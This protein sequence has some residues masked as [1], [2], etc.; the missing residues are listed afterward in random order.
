MY[1]YLVITLLVIVVIIYL[2][3]YL[4]R[5]R[6]PH[7]FWDLQP[8]S[9]NFRRAGILSKT[10]LAAIQLPDF[11][12]VTFKIDDPKINLGIVEF[13]DQHFLKGYHYTL[14]YLSWSLA[15][16]PYSNIALLTRDQKK[17]VGTIST[18]EVSLVI[19]GTQI[20]M[21]YVDYLAVHKSYR[22]K[23]LATAL[24]S[25]VVESYPLET[26]LFKIEETPLPFD[27]VCKFRYYVYNLKSLATSAPQ[28]NNKPTDWLP[29]D[30]SNI[31]L[32]Y[33]YYQ[34]ECRKFRYY[35]TYTMESFRN[36]FLPVDKILYSYVK[37]HDNR[38]TGF[39]SYFCIDM[40]DGFLTFNKQTTRI[41][42]SLVF[43]SDNITD[44]VKSLLEMTKSLGLDYFVVTNL[45][46]NRVFIDRMSFIPAKRCYLQMY[47]YGTRGPLD[48]SE[49]LINI[50]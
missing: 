38:V 4:K 36:W 9:R 3:Q 50:P 24:I 47:N 43:L 11:I 45:G 5:E 46:K 32:A 25:K 27:A 33:Q 35:Q 29:L 12:T 23:R 16:T 6:T 14:P 34:T 28:P 40:K 39:A 31:E 30:I 8:V 26:F 48:P 37:L 20:N 42:E 44:D 13:I 21:G 22:G 1:K 10:R 18:K 19:T 41:A 17:I 7:H 2:Y 15:K 49:V